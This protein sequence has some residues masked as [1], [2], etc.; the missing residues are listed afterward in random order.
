LRVAES[1]HDP[2]RSRRTIRPRAAMSFG[3]PRGLPLGRTVERTEPMEMPNMPIEPRVQWRAA[4][5]YVAIRRLVTMQTIPEIADRIPAVLGWLAARGREPAG[6]PFLRYRV[7]GMDRR[8]DIEAGVSVNP[9]IKGDKDII[10][11]ILP[12]G[13]YATVTHVGPFDKLMDVTAAL[14][15][16]GAREGLTWDMIETE[17]G[18]EWGCRL[19]L[20]TTN[21]SEEPDM[22]KWVTELAFRLAAG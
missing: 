16:W 3:R 18:Q 5:P 4:Q 21:P 7:M 12:A 19:E 17:N 20:Y 1:P 10:S 8:L 9:A 22:N 6:A 11:G 15:D 2:G 14:L 13:R